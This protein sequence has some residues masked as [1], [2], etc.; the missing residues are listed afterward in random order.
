MSTRDVILQMANIKTDMNAHK[1]DI[2]SLTQAEMLEKLE[3]EIQEL[4]KALAEGDVSHV[5][6]EAGDIFNYLEAIVASA[7]ETYRRRK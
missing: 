7:I 6:E 4:D 3:S 2:M 5:V 1:G